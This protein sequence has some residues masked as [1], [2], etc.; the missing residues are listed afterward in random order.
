MS[1]ISNQREKFSLDFEERNKRAS[2]H[3]KVS[4]G[5]DE[6]DEEMSEEERKMPQQW[7]PLLPFDR[8]AHSK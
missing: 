3:C 1:T 2:S 6:T 8:D 7:H 5:K 4:Q